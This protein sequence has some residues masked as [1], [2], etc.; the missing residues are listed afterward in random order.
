MVLLLHGAT[1]TAASVYPIASSYAIA[2]FRTLSLDWDAPCTARRVCAGDPGALASDT[3]WDVCLATV[4]LD[5]MMR[6]MERTTE[7]LI[8]LAHD[9]P[10]DGWDEYL[11]TLSD[12]TRVP[13][14]EKMIFAGYSEGAN[15]TAWNT[16]WLRPHSAI[17]YSGGG[18]VERPVV[19]PIPGLGCVTL[20]EEDCSVS[21]PAA[22]MYV[23]P[24][25][26]DFVAYQNK[27]ERCDLSGGWTLDH[28]GI[29]RIT[30]D[31][32]AI[33]DLA[34]FAHRPR[35]RREDVHGFPVIDLDTMSD[36]KLAELHQ[37]AHGSALEVSYGMLLTHTYLVCR[38]AGLL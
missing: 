25:G 2:G 26:D 11:T 12:G 38:A 36:A 31:S 30:Y 6:I 7:A 4:R 28:V 33:T 17:F 37:K 3:A 18:D 9:H 1:G 16:R 21:A 24:L 13:R 19:T 23:P 5:N 32:N 22:W 35:L 15:Q 27:Y 20:P 8:R 10:S 29:G 34:D 14:W